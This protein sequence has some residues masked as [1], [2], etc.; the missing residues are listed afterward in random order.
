ML[1]IDR[2]KSQFETLSSEDFYIYNHQPKTF[3]L[4]NFVI[5]FSS[6]AEDKYKEELK[7]ESIKPSKSSKSCWQRLYEDNLRDEGPFEL[8][9]TTMCAFSPKNPE[10][11]KHLEKKKFTIMLIGVHLGPPTGKIFLISLT[12]LILKLRIKSNGVFTKDA[13]KGRRF[14]A[15]F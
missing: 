3:N 10:K 1:I 14:V 8:A 4:Q 2:A 6:I 5:I 11:E 13:V 7:L 9:R 12:Y 15:E